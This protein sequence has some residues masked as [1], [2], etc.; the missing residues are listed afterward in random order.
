MRR[1]PR[2]RLF[3]RARKMPK[4]G[5]GLARVGR[6]ARCCSSGVCEDRPAPGPRPTLAEADPSQASRFGQCPVCSATT[7]V[8]MPP[9]AVKAP[10][11]VMRR[12]RQAATRSSRILLVAAS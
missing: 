7:V 3:V 11:T 5:T 4:Q 9:R 1:Q 12:G 2:A 8:V 6:P 10:V